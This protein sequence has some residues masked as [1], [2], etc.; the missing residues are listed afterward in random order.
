MEKVMD[1][2]FEACN[3]N[4]IVRKDPN[5]DLFETGL[6]N[7]IGFLELLTAIEEEF[8]MEIDPADATKTK[9][10]T[11]QAIIDYVEARVNGSC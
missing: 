7:S 3:E 9:L 6:L 4:K 2:I 8:D 10:G 1:L 5:V 11:P